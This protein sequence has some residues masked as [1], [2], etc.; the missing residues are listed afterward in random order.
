MAPSARLAV[1]ERLDSA[2]R[3]GEDLAGSFQMPL[4]AQHL[5]ESRAAVRHFQ[6][7]GGRDKVRPIDRGRIMAKRVKRAKRNRATDARRTAL[8]GDAASKSGRDFATAAAHHRAGRLNEAGALYAEILNAEPDNAAALHQFGMLHLQ[9]GRAEEAVALIDEA[10]QHQPADSAWLADRGRAQMAAGRTQEAAET[11]R[12]AL[13]ANPANHAARI[14]LGNALHDLGLPEEALRHYAEVIA[15][16][17]GHI[18]GLTN[19]ALMQQK[20][21]DHAAARDTIEAAL[22]RAPRN[23]ELQFNAGT[24]LQA[25]G[26][27][28]E[29]EAAYKAAIALAPTM[30][31]AHVNLG[32]TYLEAERCAE[33]VEAYRRAIE[34][35][36]R[37][38]TA[39][40]NLAAALHQLGDYAAAAAANEHAV[41][42]E[43]ENVVALTNLGQSLQ[44][45]DRPDEAVSVYERVLKITPGY[46]PA[47]ANLAIALQEAGRRED[48]AAIFDFDRLLRLRVIETPEG[49]ADLGAFN[50]ALRAYI[51]NHPTLI[52][53]RP[54]KSTTLGS[55]TLELLTGDDPVVPALRRVLRGAVEDFVAQCAARAS[56][57][58]VVPAH[59]RLVTWAVVLQSGGHQSPH[60]HPAGFAS[61]VYYVGLPDEVGRDA[62]GEAGCLRFGPSNTNV[63]GNRSQGGFLER[64]AMPAE[65]LMVLFPSYFW[66]HTIPFTSDDY[67]ICIAFDAVA[68]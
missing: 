59:W 15:V 2:Q 13:D 27:V 64:L 58:G 41:A 4:E 22:R 6:R 11:F 31:A 30:V 61:G 47:L 45:D 9:V 66:H 18:G 40:A 62:G 49:Y 28:D 37:I 26:R 36:P 50:A 38:A 43:P 39:H 1:V 23:A 3:I 67:R 65:G 60:T 33:A 17:P 55:Q 24:V 7:P 20:L 16:A 8:A 68:N 5:T 63:I 57:R 56:Y 53:D 29:A 52:W 25:Q 46:V 48:A 42:L 21:G 32:T 19:L 54:A 10:L 51:L 35:E 44:E 12:R 14:A 34:I